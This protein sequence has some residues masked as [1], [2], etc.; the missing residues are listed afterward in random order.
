M[1][2]RYEPGKV[3]DDLDLLHRLIVARVPTTPTSATV[4]ITRVS[5]GEHV[6]VGAVATIDGPTV[7]YEWQPSFADLYRVEWHLVH[8]AGIDVAAC[9]EIRINRRISPVGV[10]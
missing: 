4:T 6:V 2:R 8:G 10:A 7:S 1:I 3:G 9:A 5:T